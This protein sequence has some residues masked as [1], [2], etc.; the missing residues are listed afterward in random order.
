MAQMP[1]PATRTIPPSRIQAEIT[2]SGYGGRILDAERTY[3]VALARA[4]IMRR[5]H[6]DGYSLAE[7]GRKLNRHHSTVL[8]WIKRLDDVE[9]FGHCVVT[10]SEDE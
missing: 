7:I 9:R 3:V 6:R 10:D 5:L 1:N 8:Y 4:E 2:A